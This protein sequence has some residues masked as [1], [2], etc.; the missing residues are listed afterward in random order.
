MA[1]WYETPKSNITS[2]K[3]IGN[4]SDALMTAALTVQPGDYVTIKENQTGID[5][6]FIV[7]GIDKQLI[8]IGDGV[9]VTATWY[10]CQ[11]QIVTGFILDVDLLDVGLLGV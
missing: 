6:G 7:N 5:T 2:C 3:I 4:K 8:P 1:A 10:L 11:A 9:L